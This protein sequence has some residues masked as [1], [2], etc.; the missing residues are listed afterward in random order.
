MRLEGRHPRRPHRPRRPETAVCH[1]PRPAHA[2]RSDDRQRRVH[3][4]VEG[5]RAQS[6]HG[7]QHG[8]GRHRVRHGQ[9]HARNFLGRS[10]R[11][12]PRP[13]HG[14]GPERL[15]QPGQ[16]RARLSLHLPGCARRAGHRNQRSH[17]AG[18]HPRPGRTGQETSARYGQHGL[19]RE[20]PDVR[21]LLHHS[22][23]RRS[24]PH[25]H[26][27]P[28]RGPCRDGIGRGAATDSELG[29]VRTNPGQTP[30]SRQ[31]VDPRHHEQGEK[32]PEKSCFCRRREPDR[33]QGR[34][35]SAR[36]GHRSPDPARQPGAHPRHRRRKPPRPG[37]RARHR[38]A[39][40]GG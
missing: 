38:P 6:G 24:P 4:A 30:R 33:A 10:L 31:P 40:G 18:R 22:Q 3:R 12:P 28:R 37:R 19:Q 39:L 34:A 36:R 5:Q 17:E 13:H 9:P 8:P 27:G 32:R 7:A 25:H 29:G 16:Q 26:R 14:H 21:S 1:H 23:A 2:R 35:A 20:K 11:R 15:P